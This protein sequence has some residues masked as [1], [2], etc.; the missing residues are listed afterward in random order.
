MQVQPREFAWQGTPLYVFWVVYADR[1]DFPLD[2]AAG[3]TPD[4]PL[5]KGR[6]F[7]SKIWQ[8]ERGTSAETESLEMIVSGPIDFPTA[9]SAYLAQLQTMIVPDTPGGEN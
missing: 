8:G 9:K 7:L 4:A 2:E 1:S 5:T 6:Y 3:S